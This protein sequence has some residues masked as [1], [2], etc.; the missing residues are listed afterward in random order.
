MTLG[1]SNFC[2]TVHMF[3]INRKEGIGAS[4]LRWK[5]DWKK[6]I[7]YVWMGHSVYITKTYLED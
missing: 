5:D 4:H 3:V 6:G 7:K 2:G 1:S